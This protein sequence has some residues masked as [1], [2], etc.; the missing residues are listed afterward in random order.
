M[1]A[2]W[3]PNFPPAKYELDDSTT[4]NPSAIRNNVTTS[5]RVSM[6]RRSACCPEAS[7][8]ALR[9][10]ASMWLPFLEC[11]DGGAEH[12]AALLIILEHVEAGARGCQEHGVARLRGRTRGAHRVAHVGGLR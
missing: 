3:S 4:L 1:S 2:K 7:T 12:F 11:V 8:G 10:I 9:S 5:K 6:P